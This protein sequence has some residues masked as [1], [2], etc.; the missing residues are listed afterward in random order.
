LF[1]HGARFAKLPAVLYG[2]RQHRTSATRTDPRYSRERF[3]SLKSAA[4]DSGLLRGGLKATLVGV[5]SSLSRWYET[6]G[7]R[8]E[9]RVEIPAPHAQV[10]STLRPP[11][12]LAVMA[13]VARERW[14]AVLG[15]RGLH[16]LSDFVFVA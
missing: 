2:W 11:L 14:R 8:V 7:P 1:T 16:E 12:V 10:V 13:P 6:L 4:L 5:G 9:R 15:G 3:M